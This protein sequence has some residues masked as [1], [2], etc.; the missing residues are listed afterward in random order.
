MFN[1]VGTMLSSCILLWG[2]LLSTAA[3]LV[4]P[5]LPSEEIHELERRQTCNTATNRQCWTTS[6]A[7]NINT[8]Y[9]TSWPTTGVTR[10][11]RLQIT[12]L[13]LRLL[14]EK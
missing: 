1:L 4:T 5:Q 7:F 2:L 13:R 3:A 6:P 11:V 8:D 9:E 12:S 14:F 10:S